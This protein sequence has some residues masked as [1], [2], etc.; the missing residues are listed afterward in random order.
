MKQAQWLSHFETGIFAALDQ[1]R[2]EL[3]ASGK[4]VYNLSIGTP[5]FQPAPHIMEA[6]TEACKKPENYVYALKDMNETL[7]AVKDY[8][9]KRF[10]VEVT[11]DEIT[12]VHGS[13]EGIGH[14]GM[15]LTSPG[16]YAIL[17]N[18]G[19]PIFEAGA[20]LGG[21]QLYF[22]PLKQEN[23]FLPVFE[24]IPEEI[25]RKTK[26]MILSYPYNPV[27]AVANDEVYEKAI[28][29]AKKYDIIIIHDNAY[30]DIIYDGKEGKSFLSY[31][32]AKEVGIEFFSLSKSFN[33]T[34]LRISF[35]VGNREVIDAIKLL[36]SQI[37]FGMPI[38]IQK[39]A[40][41]ALTGPL[42]MVKEQCVEYQAR[43]D[44]LC[45]GLRK[46]GWNVPD[47]QGTMFVWAP[48]PEKFHSSEEFCIRLMEETG[49][50]CTPGYAF[51]SLGE[52]YVR[53][54]LVMPPEKLREVV[55]IIDESGI[56]K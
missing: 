24:E 1:K 35:A 42:D 56:L 8:Y 48:I 17:P 51:G 31:E 36:R 25:A 44:A 16:D 29:F 13:Q 4:K 32:G 33:V 22:Y 30:S 21:A 50:I 45:G 11:T 3:I 7:A 26:F 37:D 41:A 12:S 20:Y 34:G 43:R 19:Y 40:V 10:G 6:M 47:S 14:I 53:F 49:V 23:G 38:P 39:A 28:A 18:P 2:D 15:A 52:G 46:I 54:A 27:C 9:K 55:R 5:D